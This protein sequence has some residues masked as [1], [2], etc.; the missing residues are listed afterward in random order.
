MSLETLKK[1][2][3]KVWHSAILN[4][5]I[6]PHCKRHR[7]NKS[8]RE[9]GN[10]IFSRVMVIKLLYPGMLSRVVMLF[11]ILLTF[12]NMTHAAYALQQEA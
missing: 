9:H 8:T 1:K 6:S 11:Q 12:S 10:I 7:E 3:S 2:V 4:S 5:K